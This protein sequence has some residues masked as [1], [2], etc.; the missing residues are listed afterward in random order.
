MLRISADQIEKSYSTVKAVDGISFDVQS[1]QIF[2]LLGPNGAGKSSLIRIL[3]GL[4]RPDA[5][6]IR[7]EYKGEELRTLPQ[8]CYGYLP[9]DRGLYQDKTV[10]QNLTYIGK[11]RGMNA[12]DIAQGLTLWCTRLDLLEKMDDNLSKLSKGNQQKVQL[13][14]CVLHK[15]DLLILD[16]PFSGLDPVNQ[17]HVVSILTELKLSCSTLILIAH[18]MSLF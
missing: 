8:R 5:G 2:A 4:T 12:A 10:R 17:E 14:S 7:I 18:H 6:Q 13:I 16:E 3:V 9:E 15:P 11:L 1:G